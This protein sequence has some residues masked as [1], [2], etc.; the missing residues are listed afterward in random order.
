MDGLFKRHWHDSEGNAE[1]SREDRHTAPISRRHEVPH[2]M[3]PV[4]TFRSPNPYLTFIYITI[5]FPSINLLN[6]VMTDLYTIY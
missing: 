3:V 1:T 2:R 5:Y 6:V 4:I